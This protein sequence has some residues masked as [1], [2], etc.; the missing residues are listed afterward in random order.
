[1]YEIYILPRVYK[2]LK[3]LPKEYLH[4]ILERIQRLSQEPRP[5]G[6]KKLRG[7]E[8]VYRMRVGDYRILYRVRDGERRVVILNIGHRK[9]IY[10][11]L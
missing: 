8:D 6:C 1:M 9:D 5:Q 7:R 2:T 11:H 3:R 10:R 4:R